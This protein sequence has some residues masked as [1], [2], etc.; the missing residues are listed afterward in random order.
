[1]L[2]ILLPMEALGVPRNSDDSLYM[3]WG[4][5]Q[6]QQGYDLTVQALADIQMQAVLQDKVTEFQEWY[7][8]RA[9]FRSVGT[10]SPAVD[11]LIATIFTTGLSLKW[12]YAILEIFIAMVMAAG[13]AV[14]LR[15]LFGNPAAAAGLIL[16]SFVIL[17]LRGLHYFAA[18]EL[19][20]SLSLVL[21]G[22]MLR[23]GAQSRLPLLLGGWFTALAI[24]PIGLVYLCV[25]LAMLF[26]AEGGPRA[27]T[28]YRL[29]IIAGSLIALAAGVQLLTAA[30]PFL[31]MENAFSERG[32]NFSEGLVKN[33]TEIY[34][35]L[36]LMVH[37]G[38]IVVV[39]VGLLG[40]ALA[41]DKV[42]RRPV[43][44]ATVAISLPLVASIFYFYPGYPGEIF[45][46]L[47]VP[48]VI[49]LAGASGAL[50]TEYVSTER[51]WAVRSIAGV[52]AVIF[53]ALTAIPNYQLVIQNLNDR[54]Q[55]IDEKSVATQI[56]QLPD[57]T[58]I[59]YLN[60]DITT[61]AVLLA[62]GARF[63]A[64]IG[65]ILANTKSGKALILERR[66]ALV[67]ITLPDWL[68]M[69]AAKR[70]GALGERRYG[71]PFALVDKLLVAREQ[72][73][74]PLTEV[75][76]WVT[77]GSDANIELIVHGNPPSAAPPENTG[78]RITVPGGYSGWMRLDKWLK[79]DSQT[80]LTQLLIT[81]PHGK[82]W[83]EG[84]SLGPPRRNLRWPWTDR[85]LLAIL[86]R[87]STS[88]TF[89]KLRF[90]IPQLMAGKGDRIFLPM[91]RRQDP[92]LS[93]ESGIV[94]L[95]TV[96]AP[97]PV[98]NAAPVP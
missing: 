19:A 41:R 57:R 90:S 56:A 34:D 4:G 63:G 68:N 69:H 70:S 51:R 85:A 83:I 54:Q 6:I 28:R 11:L 58:N 55:I 53:V 2:I 77:N 46:R 3:L 1:M 75:H 86:D 95:K 14:F 42:L 64:L 8:S 9:L 94:F 87:S 18:N 45:G 35:F 65:P 81:L 72:A 31:G 92:V 44:A 16:L 10:H 12:S 29:L 60:A 89:A 98:N 78:R 73:N 7:R 50:L 84:V 62:G 30:L 74:R 5:Q 39:L 93:D 59:I 26:L 82:G 24:H 52:A 20:L 38:G 37:E 91:I 27:W 66:P 43:I 23:H 96:F 76:G 71:I 49:L 15:Q 33:L 97:R 47:L 61:N 48:F 32:L 17:P 36:T 13:I 25:G 40:F 88:G 79:P 21:W 67:A 22:Y 80:P